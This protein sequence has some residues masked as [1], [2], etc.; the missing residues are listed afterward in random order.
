[1]F[2]EDDTKI[3]N[4]EFRQ[5]LAQQIAL[6]N[7]KWDQKFKQYIA[8]KQA[9][10][11]LDISV[12]NLEREQELNFERYLK[13]LD[14]RKED[15]ANK[16]ILDLGCGEGDFVKFCLGHAITR[17]VYGLD[18]GLEPEK[19]NSGFRKYLLQG[20]F[21]EKLPIDELDYIISVSALDAPNSEEV[22]TNIRKILIL[23]L[24]AININ[25]EIRISPIRKAGIRSGLRTIEFSLK[26]WMEALE[27][28]SIKNLIDYEI[29]PLDIVVAGS[30]PDVWLEHVLIIK[31]R[32]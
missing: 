32:Y 30:K 14:L 20:N 3:D 29:R 19:L 17:E 9:E 10:S 8:Q 6:P 16:K 22:T 7:E 12:P 4:L 18:T 13:F 21:E 2:L 24:M 28:L 23:A 25:G 31:K 11:L 26:K 5:F 15:L 27:N 1:M